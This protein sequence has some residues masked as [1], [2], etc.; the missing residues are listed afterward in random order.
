MHATIHVL[1][2]N[3]MKTTEQNKKGTENK[4]NKLKNDSD[5]STQVAIITS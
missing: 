2:N 4:P 1:N 5:N 3:T